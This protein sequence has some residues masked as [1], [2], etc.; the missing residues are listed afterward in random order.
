MGG[1]HFLLAATCPGQP[2]RPRLAEERRLQRD[3]LPGGR[4]IA[5]AGGGSEGRQRKGEAAGGNL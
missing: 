4:G 5:V 1:N 2:A 3:V